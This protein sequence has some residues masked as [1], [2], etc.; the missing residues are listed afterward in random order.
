MEQKLKEIFA[1]ALSI[2]IETINDGLEYK[3]ISEWDSTAHMVLVASIEDAFD[4]MLDTDDVVDMSSFAKA[5]E[6]IKKY[7]AE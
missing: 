6:I 5:K 7:I 4:I 3:S 2:S 1:D